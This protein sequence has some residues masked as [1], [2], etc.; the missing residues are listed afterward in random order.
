V[1]EIRCGNKK[2]GEVSE[3]AQGVLIRLCSSRFCKVQQNE[4]VEHH[5]NLEKVNEN[6]IIY[7]IET[8]RYKKPEVKGSFK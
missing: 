4:I 1:P 7:P 3:Y 5:W 2:H 6:Q 8:K